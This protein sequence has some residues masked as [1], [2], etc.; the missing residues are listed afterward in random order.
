V[1]VEISRGGLWCF[2]G[3]VMVFLWCVC[4]LFVGAEMA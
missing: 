1:A 3:G 4:Q 2:H